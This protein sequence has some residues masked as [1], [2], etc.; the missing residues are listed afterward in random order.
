[1]LA[2][3]SPGA[4]FH[5]IDGLIV[6][7]GLVQSHGRLFEPYKGNALYRPILKPLD[8]NVQNIIRERVGVRYLRGSDLDDFHPDRHA[9]LETEVKG[10]VVPVPEID[11]LS[12]RREASLEDDAKLVLVG[13][14]DAEQARFSLWPRSREL[15]RSDD[16][17]GKVGDRNFHH[18][19]SSIAGG[20]QADQ[21]DEGE[22]QASFPSRVH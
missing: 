18:R 12:R 19:L 13:T 10:G 9:V 15:R 17:I 11:E 5:K 1:M 21:R 14:C 20:Q 4:V 22:K 8:Q 6:R 7:L 2:R 16:A 3:L